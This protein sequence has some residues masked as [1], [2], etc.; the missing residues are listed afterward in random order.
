MPDL[1]S[2]LRRRV[3]EGVAIKLS[4]LARK[5]ARRWSGWLCGGSGP[6]AVKP[7]EGPPSRSMRRSTPRSASAGR[8]TRS[9]PPPF[10]S[11]PGSPR[12]SPGGAGRAGGGGGSGV[13]RVHSERDDG[14]TV[15]RRAEEREI[16]RKGGPPSPRIAGAPRAG[17]CFAFDQLPGGRLGSAPTLCLADRDLCLR[18]FVGIRSGCGA[19]IVTLTI[20]SFV[21]LMDPPTPAG[22]AGDRVRTGRRPSAGSTTGI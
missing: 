3:R 12:L 17:A 22:E 18:A 4:P 13:R 10:P 20:I 1:E 6:A 15:D 2:A 21:I 16:E 19:I 14:P 11:A 9:P 8:A 5:E 7:G